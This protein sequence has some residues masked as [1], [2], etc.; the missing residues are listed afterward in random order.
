MKILFVN[1]RHY[2]GGGDS[3]YTFNLA[4]LL[5]NNN[6]EVNYF[7]MQDDRNLPDTNSDLFV[8]HVDYRELNKRK[9][10]LNDF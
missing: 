10:P 7:A 6:H 9:N 8:R 3:T 1:T 2:Y 5:I 4:K